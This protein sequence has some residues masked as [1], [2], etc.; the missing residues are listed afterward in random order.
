MKIL[1]ATDESKFSKNAL[2]FVGRC[3]WPEKAEFLIL[4]VNEIDKGI[5]MELQSDHPTTLKEFQQQ[6]YGDS[7][8]LISAEVDALKEKLPDHPID[9]RTEIGSA[10]ECILKAIEDWQP[11]VLIMGS[12]GRTG[13][14]KFLLGSVAESVLAQAPCTVVIVKDEIESDQIE[15]SRVLVA[16]ENE[17]CSKVLADFIKEFPLKKTTHCKVVHVVLPVL[18]NSLMSLLPAA[19]TANIAEDRWRKGREYT[20]NF[21]ETVR[22]TW[23][24]ADIEPLVVEGDAKLEI[25]DIVEKWKPHVVL[26]GSHKKKGLSTLGSV[27]KAIVAHSPCS[28][29]VIPVPVSKT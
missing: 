14:K 23:N 26:L 19:L 22:Q 9:G 16:L 20:E 13:V 10:R 1:I 24:A 17:Q 3:P 29:A 6:V 11:E 8:K 27:S 25:L 15:E 5:L 12:H 28:A 4:N 2:D 18:V 21:S 7:K